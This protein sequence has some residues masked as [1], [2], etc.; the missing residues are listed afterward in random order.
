LIVHNT[1]SAMIH[2]PELK[3]DKEVIELAE[4]IVVDIDK[5]GFFPKPMKLEFEKMYKK[6]LILTKKRYMGEVANKKGE[7]ID[8]VKKGIVLT[9]RDN[10]KVLVNLYSEIAKIILNNEKTLP[11]ILNIIINHINN[12]FSMSFTYKDFV[13]TKTLSKSS[14]KA[15]TKPAHVV[16]AERMN[17][18]GISVTA[19]SRVEYLFTTKFR[20][21]KHVVQGDKVEDIDYFAN[22]KEYLRIDYLYY[23]E[24]QLI[25]P[26]D[27]LLKVGFNLEGFM[28][29]QYLLRYNKFLLTEEINE[30]SRP[31]I[32]IDGVLQNVVKRKVPTQ[33]RKSPKVTKKKKTIQKRISDYAVFQV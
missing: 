24:K 12:L 9:R 29:M 26:I 18:R 5:Q 14:Y 16:L 28:K 23:L 31:K 33:L 15:K 13:I 22:H 17:N 4:K 20:G 32:Y 25:K 21:D 3:T 7:I 10:C 19:G 30:L 11:D 2:F 8:F 6:Y 27:E 1:D